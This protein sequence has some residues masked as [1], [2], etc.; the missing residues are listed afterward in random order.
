MFSAINHM[1][2]SLYRVGLGIAIGATFAMILA[3]TIPHNNI[4]G[5]IINY[6]VLAVQPIPKLILLPFML[7]LLGLGDASKIAMFGIYSFFQIFISVWD[8][9]K[10]IDREILDYMQTSQATHINVVKHVIWPHSMPYFFTGLKVSFGICFSVIFMVE[11][12]AST[13][14]IGYFLLNSWTRSANKELA[15]SIFLIAFTGIVIIQLMSLIERKIVRW[16]NTR[17]GENA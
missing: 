17:R 9:S 11:S 6:L 7:S 3:I 16:N 10:Y 8:S 4:M 15:F 1:L 5:K 12:F 14:G 13:S 2:I